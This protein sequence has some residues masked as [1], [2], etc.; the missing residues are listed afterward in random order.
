MLEILGRTGSEGISRTS[1]PLHLMFNGVPDTDGQRSAGTPSEVELRQGLW[2][3]RRREDKN[4]T[5]RH[6]DAS[7]RPLAAP[8]I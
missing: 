6:P 8:H 2:M 4:F 3:S 7:Q 5:G 1:L